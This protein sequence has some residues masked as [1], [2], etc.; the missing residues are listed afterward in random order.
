MLFYLHNALAAMW[1]T[2]STITR[3]PNLDALAEFST[4]E[5]G[6]SVREMFYESAKDTYQ[7]NE[8]E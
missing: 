4:P 8:T 1:Y 2:C 7:A 6:V 3:S 5:H